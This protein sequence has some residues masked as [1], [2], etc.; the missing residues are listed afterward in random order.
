VA[1][2][3]DSDIA[4]PV[5]QT[6][7]AW[8]QVQEQHGYQFNDLQFAK[9]SSMMMVYHL[10]KGWK[11]EY[12]A[13]PCHITALT[14]ASSVS[15][16]HQAPA[17]D[18]PMAE[19]HRQHDTTNGNCHNTMNTHHDYQ[20]QHAGQLPIF[21]DSFS[22]D[23]NATIDIKVEPMSGGD[24][25]EDQHENTQPE[26]AQQQEQQVFPRTVTSDSN[27]VLQ[28]M[29]Q[30]TSFQ[31]FRAFGAVRKSVGEEDLPQPHEMHDSSSFCDMRHISVGD[32]W[33]YTLGRG[34]KQQTSAEE[35]FWDRFFSSL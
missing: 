12:T 21:D 10:I 15:T 8:M 5:A 26:N 19:P 1:T 34:E 9:F 6:W 30:S 20:Q 7:Q 25:C 11:K 24:G 17:I 13:P 32:V 2:E 23:V 28:G 3:C 16:Y 33:D 29:P 18:M 22:N 14:R 4:C 35:P 31:D 27:V